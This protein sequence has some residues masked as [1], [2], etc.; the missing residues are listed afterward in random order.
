LLPASSD[1]QIPE[2][3]SKR[4]ENGWRHA[5][6]ASAFNEYS[7]AQKESGRAG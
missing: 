1:A 2:R 5:R 4:L 3:L 6:V 7:K